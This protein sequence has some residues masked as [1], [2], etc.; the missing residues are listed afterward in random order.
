ML[1]PLVKQGKIVY[2]TTTNSKR[3]ILSQIDYQTLSQID[4][5]FGGRIG[6]LPRLPDGSYLVN[7]SNRTLWSDFGGG[8]KAREYHLEALERELQEEAP[9]WAERM[10]EALPRGEIYALE[11]FYP[12]DWKKSKATIRVMILCIIEFKEEWIAEFEPSPEVLLLRRIN[13]TDLKTLLQTGPLNL[14]LQQLE[15]I[16]DTRK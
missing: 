13:D 8:V 15:K 3:S 11:E 14:G 7:L 16:N 4:K 5:G 10:L 12:F 6:V 1:Y 9:V 2:D